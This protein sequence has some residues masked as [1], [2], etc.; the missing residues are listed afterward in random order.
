MPSSEPFRT[1]TASMDPEGYIFFLI[2]IYKDW[3]FWAV[4][5]LG[6]VELVPPISSAV[7]LTPF[8]LSGGTYA[9]PLKGEKKV[10]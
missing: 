2:I 8:L 7:G 5:I 10:K 6:L 3:A 9:L 1:D 4:P